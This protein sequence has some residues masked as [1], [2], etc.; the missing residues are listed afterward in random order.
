M[1]E[2]AHTSTSVGIGAV[3]AV[4]DESRDSDDVGR[5]QPCFGDGTNIDFVKGE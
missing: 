2:D 4:W 5:L 3:F 1:D